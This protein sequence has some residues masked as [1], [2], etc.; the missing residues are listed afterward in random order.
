MPMLAETFAGELGHMKA[1][2]VSRFRHVDAPG[3]IPL[4]TVVN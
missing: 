3:S 2:S 1:A 4:L